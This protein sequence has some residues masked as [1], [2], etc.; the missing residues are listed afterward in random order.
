MVGCCVQVGGASSASRVVT[1]G[2][3]Q[4]S[5]LE[6]LF[7][8]LPVNALA[9]ILQSPGFFFADDVTVVW[10][11]G[12]DAVDGGVSTKPERTCD[13]PLNAGKVTCFQ[14]N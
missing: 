10:R 12:R 4:G 8:L 2:V 14:E 11:S 3:C 6:P 7:L 13:L 5:V 1:N 9:A